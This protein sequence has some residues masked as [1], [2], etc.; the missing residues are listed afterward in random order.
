MVS[1]VITVSKFITLVVFLF[2]LLARSDNV[3][4]LKYCDYH[5]R[6]NNKERCHFPLCF[7]I[8]PLSVHFYLPYIGK[9]IYKVSKPTS[10]IT[11]PFLHLL[12]YEV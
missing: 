5:K 8:F 12:P 6:R 9:E 4:Q 7:A 10:F 3:C 11:F 1:D 2:L